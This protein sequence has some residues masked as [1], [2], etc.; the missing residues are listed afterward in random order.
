MKRIIK[1]IPKIGKYRKIGEKSGNYGKIHQSTVARLCTVNQSA[2]PT[3][4]HTAPYRLY[5]VAATIDFSESISL[6]D[7]RC[8]V[9]II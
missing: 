9:V 4:R 5:H 6:T 3:F 7:G 2:I 1:K 8:N